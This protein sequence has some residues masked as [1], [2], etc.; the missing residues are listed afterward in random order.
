MRSAAPREG[1]RPGS[2]PTPRSIP[3]RAPLAHARASQRALDRL[4]WP[5]RGADGAFWAGWLAAADILV[6][7]L[8]LGA[9]Q[10]FVHMPPAAGLVWILTAGSAF[11]WRYTF[12]GTLSGSRRHVALET[13]SGGSPGPT[14]AV[15]A[16]AFGGFGVFWRAC[17]DRLPAVPPE[18]PPSWAGY[19]E[20]AAGFAVTATLLIVVG[21]IMEEFCFRGW[22][23]PAFTK[24]YGVGT[25]LFV[26]SVLFGILHAGPL[27]APY[28]VVA[29]LALGLS[30]HLTGSVWVGV[31]LHGGYNAAALAVQASYPSLES[32]ARGLEPLGGGWSAPVGLMVTTITLAWSL[33]RLVPRGH[34][35]VRGR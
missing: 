8:W 31:V 29:G 28:Y 5:L 18:L 19:M 30:V 33:A 35:P 14:V 23:M 34:G 21:P 20:T 22:V 27:R 16:L 25:G 9:L 4:L 6:W 10:L 15:A 26:S 32:L 3:T 17:Y 11:L 2:L 12:S 13:G 1:A 24:R 7:V